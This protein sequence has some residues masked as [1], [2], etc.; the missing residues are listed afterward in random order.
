M[1][2]VAVINSAKWTMFVS[3]FPKTL[4]A[5]AV[6]L[7]SFD[8]LFSREG[9]LRVPIKNS[10]TWFYT[11]LSTQFCSIRFNIYTIQNNEVNV[12]KYD[13]IQVLRLFDY[14]GLQ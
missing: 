12:L 13:V 14:Y 11:E 7:T 8:L 5:R 9:S 1:D 4:S 6:T 3:Y 10:W 2:C